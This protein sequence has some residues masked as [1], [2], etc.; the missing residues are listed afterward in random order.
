M[1]KRLAEVRNEI[2][3][4]G[5]RYCVVMGSD[6]WVYDFIVVTDEEWERGETK[7]LDDEMWVKE[8]VELMY[9]SVIVLFG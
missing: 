7:Y 2:K 5:R 1:N 9:S 8:V 6:N 3:A 4:A